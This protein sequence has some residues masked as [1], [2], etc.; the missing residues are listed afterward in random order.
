[1]AR[2]KNRRCISMKAATFKDEGRIAVEERTRTGN[3]GI[4]GRGRARSTG[5]RVWFKSMVFSR[6]YGHSR[7]VKEKFQKE[8]IIFIK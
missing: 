8:S 2:A 1:M 7:R 3:Q 6:H 5:L 4:N